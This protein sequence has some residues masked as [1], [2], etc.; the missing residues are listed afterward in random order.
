MVTF[1]IYTRLVDHEI[2][3]KEVLPARVV[4]QEVGR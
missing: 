4:R 3:V 1:F 2:R